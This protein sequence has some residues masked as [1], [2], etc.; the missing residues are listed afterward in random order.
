MNPANFT[1]PPPFPPLSDVSRQLFI[2][3]DGFSCVRWNSQA[4]IAVACVGGCL[5]GMVATAVLR[6]VIN[7]VI[8]RRK[9][10]WKLPSDEPVGYSATLT[11]GDLKPA[12]SSV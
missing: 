2:I 5:F 8:A 7:P 11:D 10:S 4:Q 6:Y 3:P 9:I 12:R 1:V